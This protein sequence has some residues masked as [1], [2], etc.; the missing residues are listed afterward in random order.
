MKRTI[1]AVF[2]CL[3]FSISALA[4]KPQPSPAS[5]PKAPPAP[6]APA[7]PTVDQILDK[8]VQALGGKAALSKLTSRTTKGTA[9]IPAANITGT[10]ETYSKA[11]NKSLTI[12]TLPQ[13]G[14]VQQGYDGTTGWSQ[15]AQEGLKDLSGE[16]LEAVK[17]DADFYRDLKLKEQYPKMVV[18]GKEKLGEREAY[19]VEAT[20]ANGSMEKLYFDAQSGLLVRQDVERDSP[21]G[22]MNI[23]VEFENYKEVDGVKIPHTIRQIFPSFALITTFTEVKHNGALDDA[24]FSKPVIKTGP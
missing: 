19:L 18:K 2:F 16:T 3:A 20:P 22:K 17:R 24:K 12:M 21:Q 4:Q 8:Y 10:L 1:T 11:P 6:A 9:E 13:L 14:L 23:S 5:S 15:N 7:L